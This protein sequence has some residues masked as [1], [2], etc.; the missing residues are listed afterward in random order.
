MNTDH[1]AS[2]ILDMANTLMLYSHNGET[3][4][5]YKLRVIMDSLPALA[6]K[7]DL[8]LGEKLLHKYFLGYIDVNIDLTGIDGP[9]CRFETR[10]PS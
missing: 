1:S 9:L 7:K 3:L 2:I 8:E 6:T 4:P 5:D 10:K